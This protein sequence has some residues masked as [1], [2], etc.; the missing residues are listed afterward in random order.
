M[1][2]GGSGSV[3][4]AASTRR[5]IRCRV[6][7]RRATFLDTT[8]AYPRVAPEETTEKFVDASRRPDVSAAV[9]VERESRSAREN[10]AL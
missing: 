1:S 6:T 8:T 3:R 5:L 2:D 4:S 9:K 7:E 10:T